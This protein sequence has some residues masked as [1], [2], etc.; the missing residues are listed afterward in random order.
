MGVGGGVDMAAVAF[1]AAGRVLPLSPYQACSVPEVGGGVDM[2]AVAFRAA[3]RVLPR[4]PSNPAQPPEVAVIHC[5][6]AHWHPVRIC[7]I[8]F[9]ESLF[10]KLGEIW[11]LFCA[12]LR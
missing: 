6:A 1:R 12:V 5:I 2:A 3:G 9:G 11:L 7:G 8:V 4:W 10:Q